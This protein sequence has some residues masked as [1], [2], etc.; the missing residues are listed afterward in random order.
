M[1]PDLTCV[2]I[3]LGD[4]VDQVGLGELVELMELGEQ[5]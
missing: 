5:L 1:L 4:L 2:L 3:D